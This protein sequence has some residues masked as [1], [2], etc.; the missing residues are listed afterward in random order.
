VRALEPCLFILVAADRLGTLH[1]V[2]AALYAATARHR[3]PDLVVL[4]QRIPNSLENAAEL[5]RLGIAPRVFTLAGSELP[6]DLC[7]HV[8]RTLSIA[9]DRN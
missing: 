3:A 9:S 8:R 5:V 6:A 7:A 4:N 2:T 1:D